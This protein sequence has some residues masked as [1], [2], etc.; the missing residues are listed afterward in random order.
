MTWAALVKALLDLINNIL[1]NVNNSKYEQLGRLRE[2]QR[3]AEADNESRKKVD[4]IRDALDRVDAGR[5][6]KP[7][8]DA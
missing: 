1:G 4:G 6:P 3:N 5:V 8:D 7:N 2:A